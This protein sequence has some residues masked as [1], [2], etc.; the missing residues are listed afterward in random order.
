M[1]KS[2]FLCLVWKGLGSSAQI[3]G[4]SASGPHACHGP[5]GSFLES[6]WT[7]I[8]FS[9]ANTGAGKMTLPALIATPPTNVIAAP[10]RHPLTI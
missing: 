6:I 2:G 5:K 7:G 10:E 3:P 4:T 9:R 8:M 1:V